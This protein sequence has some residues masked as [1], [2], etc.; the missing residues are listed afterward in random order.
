MLLSLTGF[1]NTIILL[2]SVQGVIISILL[3]FS[4]RNRSSN[5]LLSGL[6]MLI[7]LAS[8]NLYGNYQDWFHS[9]LLRF[10]AELVPLVMVMPIG[11]LVWFY[12]QSSLDP[13]FKVR[14]KQKTPFLACNY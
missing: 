3:F 11:P 10:M 4:K 14:Q 7:T 1:F 2:A 13:S 5:R 12:V 8:F 9:P 6:I